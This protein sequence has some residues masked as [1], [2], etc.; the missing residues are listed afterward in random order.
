[1]NDDI[2]KRIESIVS[3]FLDLLKLNL[4]G[5]FIDWNQFDFSSSNKPKIVLIFDLDF[6]NRSTKKLAYILPTISKVEKE[7]S[8]VLGFKFDVGYLIR[9]CKSLEEQIVNESKEL[10]EVAVPGIYHAYPLQGFFS[11]VF[12]TL[13]EKGINLRE[14][15]DTYFGKHLDLDT[16]KVS[17][18]NFE[19][20]LEYLL[21]DNSRKPIKMRN[22]TEYATITEFAFFIAEEFFKLKTAGLG[23]HYFVIDEKSNRLKTFYFF[24]SLMTI[25]VGAIEIDVKNSNKK[26]FQVISSAAEKK[27]IGLGYGTK[28]YLSV[29][30]NCN[31]LLSDEFMYPASLKVWTKSL[32]NY[33]NVWWIDENKKYKKIKP[34]Q[35]LELDYD[36]VSQFIASTKYKK[37]NI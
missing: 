33:S 9:D 35:P 20:Y 31:Y 29:L 11:A 18:K 26:I 19:D 21:G 28:M 6:I 7:I 37:V 30:E 24:D 22:Y 17:N 10:E 2:K 25:F 5:F 23:L 36:N 1:M 13:Q 3:N 15:F 34:N 4:C 12:R 27:L 14:V 8:K 16:S 32:P